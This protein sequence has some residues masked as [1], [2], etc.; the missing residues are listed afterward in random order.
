MIYERARFHQWCQR[1]GE[2]VEAF[3][4]GLYELSEHWNCG[5]LKD[6]YIRDADAT[7][8]SEKSYESLSKT[9]VI[10]N[11]PDGKL[12]CMG[13]MR[14]KVCLNQNTYMM[15]AYV[16]RGAHVGNLLG[17][18]AAIQ[19][20]LIK[21]IDE[22]RE[23]VFGSLGLMDLTEPVKIMLKSTAEPYSAHVAR[24]VPS[25]L[26]NVKQELDR[27]ERLGVIEEVFEPTPWCAPMVPV[28]KRNGEIRICVDL[29]RLN[30]AV[31]REKY[32]L[33]TLDEITSKLA[34]VTSLL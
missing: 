21:R 22:I 3:V 11:S 18:S 24:R 20:V 5:E 2:R 26:T 34:G 32:V 9:N 25:M 28:T 6:E 10:L 13:Q 7:V 8:I 12:E 30:E 14:T 16:V 27:M 23:N 17:C 29:K 1:K 33:P 15:N 31:I 19:I 4:R